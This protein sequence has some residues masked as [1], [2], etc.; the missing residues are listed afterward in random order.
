MAVT[1]GAPQWYVSF[2]STLKVKGCVF[3]FARSSSI[4]VFVADTQL[5][6]M[7]IRTN[8]PCGVRYVAC[9]AQAALLLSFL[10]LHGLCVVPIG[11]LLV[12][13]QQW[14]FGCVCLCSTWSVL[15]SAVSG[16]GILCGPLERRGADTLIHGGIRP[17]TA[18]ASC[19]H[20]SCSGGREQV[21]WVHMLSS[22]K[23]HV[24]CS[25]QNKR[26]PVSRQ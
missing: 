26:A 16:P 12:V 14:L 13:L 24:F 7:A 25:F 22:R 17:R 4:I 10:G 2:F 11:A 5:C 1:W 18:V 21:A 23:R 19:A 15:L 8:T 20:G 3:F 6:R 9:H